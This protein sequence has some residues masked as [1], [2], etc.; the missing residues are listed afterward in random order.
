MYRGDHGTPNPLAKYDLHHRPFR[1]CSRVARIQP[2]AEWRASSEKIVEALIRD[3]FRRNARAR[4]VLVGTG[5]KKL[6]YNNTHEDRTWGVCGGEEEG[7]RGI[8]GSPSQ[9]ALTEG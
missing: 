7:V 3:K 2:T 4:A 1:S 8:Y 6:V 5:H 9:G